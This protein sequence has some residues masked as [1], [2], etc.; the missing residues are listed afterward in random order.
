MASWKAFPHLPLEITGIESALCCL[1]KPIGPSAVRARSLESLEETA[2]ILGGMARVPVVVWNPRRH[3]GLA[4]SR[5]CTEYN[6]SPL[7]GGSPGEGYAVEEAKVLEKPEPSSL[8]PTGEGRGEES[9]SNAA[10]ID[11]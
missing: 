5:K 7:Y 9:G 10:S 11:S 3:M 8:I 2:H 6:L 1:E 4:G